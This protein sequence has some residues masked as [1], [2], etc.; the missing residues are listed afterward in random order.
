MDPRLLSLMV[1]L[2]CSGKSPDPAGETGEPDAASVVISGL[3]DCEGCGTGVVA[4]F[5]R[6]ELDALPLVDVVLAG[7]GDFSL[8]LPTDSGDTWLLGF[9]DV[10]GDGDPG[11]GEPIGVVGP[12]AIGAEDIADV[13]LALS[14]GFSESCADHDETAQ[15]WTTGIYAMG[16]DEGASPDA[17]PDDD[18]VSDP[19]AGS[20]PCNDPV[21]EGLDI[22]GWSAAEGSDLSGF[23]ITLA[24]PRAADCGS[25][26]WRTAARS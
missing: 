13:W 5:D 11:P 4:A 3:V 17:F 14:G 8:T 19:T 26:R 24:G 10:D 23:R 20:D 9:A 21:L 15:L 16:L 22:I 12:L 18:L 7:P 2:G 25:W 1:L 6:E